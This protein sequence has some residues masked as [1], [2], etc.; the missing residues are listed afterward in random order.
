[1]IDV[2]LIK[3]AE[4]KPIEIQAIDNSWRNYVDSIKENIFRIPFKGKYAALMKDDYMFIEGYCGLLLI[5]KVYYDHKTYLLKNPVKHHPFRIYG[6]YDKRA[7]FEG[8]MARP[9][10]GFHYM[11]MGDAGHTICTGD[12]EYPKIESIDTLKEVSLKIINS[13]RLINMTSLGAIFLPDDNAKLKSIFS[14]DT[15]DVKIKF[16]KL[17]REGLIEEIL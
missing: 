16:E 9:E 2:K 11:P 13:F 17:L 3:Q 6:V 1:M 5:D 4:E 8:F 12:I 7:W 14:N 10:I 15:E